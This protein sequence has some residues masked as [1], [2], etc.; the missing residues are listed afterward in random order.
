MGRGGLALL[1]V[2]TISAIALGE[3]SAHSATATHAPLTPTEIHSQPAPRPFESEPLPA[4]PLRASMT[5]N[6]ISTVGSNE[7]SP[8]L[9]RVVLDSEAVA[10]FPVEAESSI[11]PE[12]PALST[13]PRLLSIRRNLDDDG[14]VF[15]RV[16]ATR[17]LIRRSLDD[18]SDLAPVSAAR[19]LRTT[20]D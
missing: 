13:P 17:R 15:E 20:L 1:L 2:S 6:E 18:T 4:H 9:I 8:R 11:V 16:G 14:D 3:P 7:I 19:R 5:S 10:S 12:A